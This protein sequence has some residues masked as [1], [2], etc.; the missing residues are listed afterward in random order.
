MNL[1]TTFLAVAAT[2]LC[3]AACDTQASERGRDNDN[4][5]RDSVST[6]DGTPPSDGA[7]RNERTTRQ[8][9]TTTPPNQPGDAAAQQR[10]GERT[11]AEWNNLSKDEFQREIDTYLTRLDTRIQAAEGTAREELQRERQE[12]GR[13]LGE[14]RTAADNSWQNLRRDVLNGLRALE[15]R[16]ERR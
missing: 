6:R 1:R 10:I 9:P 12:I 5:N 7:V 3:A 15:T 14:L 8:P 4:A 16:L 11:M 2:V 13:Q